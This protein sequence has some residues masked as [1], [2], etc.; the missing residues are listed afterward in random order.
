M[1]FAWCCLTNPETQVTANGPRL[2]LFMANERK[3]TRKRK[4]K[5]Y[6]F[7]QESATNSYPQITPNA[8]KKACKRVARSAPLCWWSRVAA[9]CVILPPLANNFANT[10]TSQRNANIYICAKI[11]AKICANIRDNICANICEN[12]CTNIRKI[13]K[14][15]LRKYWR[16]YL[17]KYLRKYF[18]VRWAT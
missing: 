2:K 12:I 1:Y 5:N 14:T 9:F 8:T 16:K 18:G 10:K 6:Y 15:N 11:F 3:S 4:S 13:C 17:R 7:V